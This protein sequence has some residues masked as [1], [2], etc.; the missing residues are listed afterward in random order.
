MAKLRM[1]FLPLAVACAGLSSGA[2][3]AE[4]DWVYV[5]TSMVYIA[6]VDVNSIRKRDGRLS[7]WVLRDFFEDQT[8][9]SSAKASTYRSTKFLEVVDRD[10]ERTGT[11]AITHYAGDA[12]TGQAVESG[13]IPIESVKLD[14]V[15]PGSIG[16][17]IVDFICKRAAAPR[18]APKP[19]P[20]ETPKPIPNRTT[21]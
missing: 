2:A 17:A 14:Y 3:A 18:S 8:S 5:D 6:S 16:A 21:L 19:P 15:I 12:G 4:S 9:K 1:C 7:A 11:A 10:G 20:V 13:S